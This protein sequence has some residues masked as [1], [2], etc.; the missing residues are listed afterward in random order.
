RIRSI[1]DRPPNDNT[2]NKRGD[3][4]GISP[5][6]TDT[7]GEDLFIA[8]KTPQDLNPVRPGSWCDDPIGTCYDGVSCY[9]FRYSRREKLGP[10][11][12]AHL[13][14]NVT[15]TMVGTSR[16]NTRLHR[17][18]T[19][20]SVTD[21]P[22]KTGCKYLVADK[23]VCIGNIGNLEVSNKR[24]TGFFKIPGDGETCREN[25]RIAD[26]DCV[27]VRGTGIGNIKCLFFPRHVEGKDKLRHGITSPL[28]PRQGPAALL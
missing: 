13:G 19:G 14:N 6:R 7:R 22:R 8:D 4:I 15:R 3:C 5:L 16:G 26:L 24:K 18:H 9:P 23:L 1:V 17:I 21:D 11:W 2:V 20:K 27:K 28:R 10:S 12:V 25:K